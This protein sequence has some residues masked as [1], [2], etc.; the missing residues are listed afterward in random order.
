MASQFELFLPALPLIAG[1]QQCEVDLLEVEGG[2]LRLKGFDFTSRTVRFDRTFNQDELA[3]GAM[4]EY[5][6]TLVT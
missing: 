1:V 6:A 4:A 2:G 5:I 3:S